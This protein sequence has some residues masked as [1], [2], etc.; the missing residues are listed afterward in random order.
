MTRRPG[1]WLA[2]VTVAVLGQATRLLYPVMYELGEDWDYVAA[3]AV[4]LGVVASPV[5]AGLAGPLR[6]VVAVRLGAV[7]LGAA[8]VVPSV[9]G[10]PPTWLAIAMPALAWIGAGLVLTRLGTTGRLG[11]FPALVVI[12]GLALDTLVRV[13]THNWDVAWVGNWVVAAV[14]AAA[15]FLLASLPDDG[16][17]PPT[18]VRFWFALG[19]FL[20]L[21]LLYVQNAAA[22]AAQS[23]VDFGVAAALVLLG[24]ALAVAGATLGGRR[25]PMALAVLVGG[26]ALWLLPASTSVETI[27]LTPL[28]AL[29]LGVLLGGAGT[30]VGLPGRLRPLVA[31]AAG[32]V[33]G[34][35]IVLLWSLHIDQPLPVA[36]EV[37]LVVAVVA[38]AA[39]AFGGKPASTTPVMVGVAGL[40]VAA[41]AVALVGTGASP[42]PDGLPEAVRITSLNARGAVGPDGSLRPDR[43]AASVA[44][45]DVVVLQEVA[46]G[47]PIHGTL[48]L[49]SFVAADLGMDV[50][51]AEAADPQFGNAVLS[52]LPMRVV[53][54]GILPTDGSQRRS[55]VWVEVETASGPLNVVATHLHSRSASQIDAVLGLGVPEPWVLAGD[56]NV[57]P[58]D[59]EVGRFEDA[60]LVDVVGASGDP[61]RT[62]SA[63]PTGPCDRPDW[64]FVSGDLR[65]EDVVI[66]RPTSSDHLPISV[67]LP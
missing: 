51:F 29:C 11:R 5:L 4:A 21:H 2:V 58:D 66:G 17:G 18:P 52:R 22:V 39:V 15:L 3:G 43:I 26:G 40:A 31:M 42:A 13:P 24:G 46:R 12:G 1:P 10:A 33:F 63:E 6:D 62:T 50:A 44:G 67:V 37:L 60:G 8:W 9:V 32:S 65:F 53:E 41:A 28:T 23:G 25:G 48:D 56:M 59:P 64:V 30:G 55:Y 27:L 47:W 38:M 57:A 34:L 7:A 36:R 16:R 45:S 54:R 19:P 14:G 49:A 35:A 61:C 20:A